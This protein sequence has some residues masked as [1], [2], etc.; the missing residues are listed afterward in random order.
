MSLIKCLVKARA[1]T[2]ASLNIPNTE[3]LYI[4]NSILLKIELVTH[5]KASG[6]CRG[7]NYDPWGAVVDGRGGILGD[8]VV[9]WLRSGAKD[10][11][12]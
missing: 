4:N 2:E 5:D 6:I 9:F 7:G 12:N 1:N 3:Q 11:G 8:Q 10:K